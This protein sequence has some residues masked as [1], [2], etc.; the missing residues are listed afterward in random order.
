[1]KGG[2]TKGEDKVN[3]WISLLLDFDLHPFC[4]DS[5]PLASDLDPFGF[6]MP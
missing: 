1:M 4:Q 3:L 6:E 2:Q 5:T